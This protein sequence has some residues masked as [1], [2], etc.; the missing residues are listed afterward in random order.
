MK[1]LLSASA[2]ALFCL[3]SCGKVEREK[4]DQVPVPPDENN[5]LHITWGGIA[6][7]DP[8]EEKRHW[9]NWTINLLDGSTAYGWTSDKNA[10]FPHNLQFELAGIGKVK[11]FVVDTRFTPILREDGS[12]SQSAEGSPVRKFAILGSTTGPD[13]PYTTIL[14]GEAKPNTRSEFP[15]PKEISTRWIKLQ[16]DSNWDG[17]GATRLAEF[18]ALGTLAER[19]VTDTADASGVYAHE[20]GPIAIRQKGNEIFGCYNSGVGALRGTIYGRIMRLTWFSAPEK[21]IGAAT[22][23]PAHDRLYGFWYRYSDKM[24]SPWNA[25][26]I[27]GLEKADPACRKALY[28][29]S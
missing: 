1:R 26:K 2:I 28:P 13:G 16:I 10:T 15:L 20:Y 12:S 7:A 6:M 24:G 29:E 5:I 11:A 18:E 21:S 27:G 14:Q 23:V 4:A 9:S 3:A 25:A 17:K 22:L 19:G 8:G